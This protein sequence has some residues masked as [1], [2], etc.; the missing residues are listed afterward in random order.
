[1]AG[2]ARGFTLLELLVVLAIVGL[3]TAGVSLSLPDARPL[4]RDAQRL[5]ALL[6][7][8]RSQ[9][10]ARALPIEWRAT[11][12]GFE[13]TGAPATGT[14]RPASNEDALAPR[15]WLTEGLQARIEHP[16]GA[17]TLRLGPEPLIP[18]QTLVLSL[19]ERRLRLVSDG[20]QPF[21]VQS[22]ASGAR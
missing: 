21:H 5:A 15:D 18:A 2:R 7:A 1:M 12:H 14:A 8:A 4:E 9:A 3:A 11:A 17:A 22:N 19:G 10:R 6:E 20:F 13:F 16:A